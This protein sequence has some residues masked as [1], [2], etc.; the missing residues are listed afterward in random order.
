MSPAIRSKTDRNANMVDFNQ[1]RP[2]EAVASILEDTERKFNE[3][4][5]PK[6]TRQRML[7]ER[8]RQGK[9]MSNRINLDLPQDIKDRLIALARRERVP[10]SQVCAFLLI[11]SLI[12][13][14][15]AENPFWGFQLESKSPKYDYLLDLKKWEKSHL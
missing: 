1:T 12:E 11:P 6:A 14:E 8:D 3:A 15:K 10:I 2:D 5:L 9:R 4:H 7:K 13:M